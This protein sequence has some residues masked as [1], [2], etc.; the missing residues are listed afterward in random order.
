LVANQN[1]LVT[2]RDALTVVRRS[3]ALHTDRVR[4]VDELRQR[5]KIRHWSERTAQVVLI[6]ARNDHPP[7]SVSQLG[8]QLNET[9]VKELRLIDADNFDVVL[10]R[11][12]HC[13]ATCDGNRC[14]LSIV[15]CHQPF[16]RIAVV[17]RR[18]EYLDLL[19]GDKRSAKPPHE[20]FT[21][22]R[23]HTP[24]DDFYST[25]RPLMVSSSPHNGGGS[26]RRWQGA[27]TPL[28]YDPA[29]WNGRTA[30]SPTVRRSPCCHPFTGSLRPR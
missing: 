25:T 22:A 21:L 12:A 26:Y 23:E 14:Q 17:G 24:G 20:L 7:A 8:D 1:L 10:E 2:A 28:C 15:P 5:Q 4:L 29:S 3:P 13:I 27:V 18:F 11:R 16:G 30:H 6:E 9:V 19:L